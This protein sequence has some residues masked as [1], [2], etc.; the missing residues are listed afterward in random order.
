MEFRS[1]EEKGEVLK[2]KPE[3]EENIYL[4]DLVKGM[5]RYIWNWFNGLPLLIRIALILFGMYILSIIVS[6]ILHLII[7][8][9]GQI[10]IILNTIALL[11]G[12]AYTI[13]GI[14]ASV[15]AIYDFFFKKRQKR[16]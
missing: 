14:F 15:I 6:L 12:P 4:K 10:F 3:N 13:L 2:G 1:K 9:I 7:L 16:N 8:L 5:V 11:L